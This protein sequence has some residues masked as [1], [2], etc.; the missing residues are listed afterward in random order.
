MKEDT[1]LHLT[2][3][4][5]LDL[6]KKVRASLDELKT[7]ESEDSTE[8]GFKHTASNVGLCAG[9]LAKSGTSYKDKFVTLETAM[10]PKYFKQIGKVPYENPQMYSMKYRG[11]GHRCPMEHDRPFSKGFSGGC[12][13]RCRVFSGKNRTPTIEEAKQ[14]Y[15]NEIEK[16][17]SKLSQQKSS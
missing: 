6:L 3:A 1:D 8:T 11:D 2:D 9:V 10:W 17:T 15:D 5:Y 14:M 12:F 16:W 7:I 13:Y 4:Q